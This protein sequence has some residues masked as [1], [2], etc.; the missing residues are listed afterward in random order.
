MSLAFGLYVFFMSVIF[1]G[2]GLYM[3]HAYR[4]NLRKGKQDR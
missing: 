1:S 3:D 2:L 4:K